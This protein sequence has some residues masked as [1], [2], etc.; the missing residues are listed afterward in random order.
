[1]LGVDDQA[2]VGL[3]REA[4]PG[5]PRRV[6]MSPAGRTGAGFAAVRWWPPGS[7]RVAEPPGD[8]MERGL[9][10][11]AAEAALWQEMFVEQIP[12]A[13]KILRTVDESLIRA[14]HGAHR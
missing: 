13:A 1:L 8:V 9:I 6:G 12:L 11:V 10:R 5:A 2:R 4:R 3:E 14:V 7:G